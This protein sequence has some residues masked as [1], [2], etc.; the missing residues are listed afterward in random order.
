MD[1]KEIQPVHPKGEQSWLFI[2]RTDA[3]AET[4]ILWQPHPK[5]F[6]LIGKDP[7]AG[8]DWGQEEKRMTEDE[9]AGWH[10]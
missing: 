4:P 1:C 10:H 7:D 3:E 2:G 5:S 9:M 6:P 8:R